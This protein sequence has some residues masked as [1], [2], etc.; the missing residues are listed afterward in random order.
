MLFSRTRPTTDHPIDE[1]E[2]RS[3]MAAVEA[4]QRR[5]PYAFGRGDRP[6]R[7]RRSLAGLTRL[8]SRG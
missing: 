4:A 6:R 2:R 7:Q 5:D 8:R 1:Y 3:L